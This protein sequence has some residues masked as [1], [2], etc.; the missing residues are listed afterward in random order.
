VVYLGGIGP[1][2]AARAAAALIEAGARALV[3]WGIAGGLDP[4]ARPGDLVLP[5]AVLGIGN[6]RYEADELWRARLTETLGRRVRVHSGTMIQV[7]QPL[8]DEAAKRAA[9]ESS[10]ACAVD[11]E[12]A[13][14]AARAN[15]A[16]LPFLVVRGVSDA[17]ETPIPTGALIGVD[18]EGNPRTAAVL[19][20]LMRHPGQLPDMLNVRRTYRAA[21]ATLRSVAETAGPDLCFRESR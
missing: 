19:G 14:I 13:A 1:G 6:T 5:A 4:A 2:R 18:A 17:V 15:R 3:S 7:D 12:S 11:M 8:C 16:K 10:G 9:F 21:V 20:W